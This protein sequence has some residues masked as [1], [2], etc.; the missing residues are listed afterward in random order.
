MAIELD[1]MEYAN[2]ADAQA[3]Y[4][5][6]DV[7]GSD[8]LTG[9][10]ASANAEYDASTSAAKACDDDTGT[11]WATGTSDPPNWWKYDFGAGVT[12]VVQKVCQELKHS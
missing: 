3:A 8:I 2:D 9:G 5:S 7:Y 6:S 10:T 11:R 12:K 1:Y 4:P